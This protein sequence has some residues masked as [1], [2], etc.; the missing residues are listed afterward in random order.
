LT[1]KSPTATDWLSSWGETWPP[2]TV[3]KSSI[4]E[5]KKL[6]KKNKI[7]LNEVKS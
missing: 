7:Y 1:A 6:N 2:P 3:C 4:F 5:F